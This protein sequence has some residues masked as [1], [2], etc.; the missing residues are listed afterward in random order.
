MLLDWTSA[1]GCDSEGV[2]FDAM[3]AY[4]ESCC[5]AARRCVAD[6]TSYIFYDA[7]AEVGRVALL[8]EL[9]D[10]PSR[11]GDNSTDATATAGR[12]PDCA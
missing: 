1:S 12:L 3:G 11:E 9:T 7:A 4:H 6:S 10:C 8:I 5:F 2:A